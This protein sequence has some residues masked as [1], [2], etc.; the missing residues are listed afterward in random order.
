[1]PVEPDHS[2]A[3][4][5]LKAYA[6][7]R[8]EQAG[9]GL[10]LHP[11]MRKLLQ[12][13]VA[14][15][16]PRSGSSESSLIASLIRFWPRIS[17]AAIAVVLACVLL[18]NHRSNRT[19]RVE[20]ARV[21]YNDG[22][23]PTTPSPAPMKVRL[24]REED[25]G[26]LE[27]NLQLAE[28]SSKAAA[29]LEMLKDGAEKRVDRGS[30]AAVEK[31]A[32]AKDDALALTPMP[33]GSSS[34]RV[35]AQ[36]PAKAL[37]ATPSGSQLAIAGNR[38][39][40]GA[41]SF[42]S[43]QSTETLARTYALKLGVA[44]VTPMTNAVV[45]SQSNVFGKQAVAAYDA[46]PSANYFAGGVPPAPPPTVAP[47]SGPAG[48]GAVA[49]STFSVDAVGIRSKAEASAA[50]GM[51]AYQQGNRLVSRARFMNSLPQRR[52]AP[53]PTSSDKAAAEP[54]SK[55][56]EVEQEGQRIAIVDFD[57]SVYNGNVLGDEVR[58]DANARESKQIAQQ[59]VVNNSASGQQVAFTA[60][61]TNRTLRKLVR[62][63][64][65]L[66]SDATNQSNAN[67][68]NLTQSAL[69]S[70]Q[71]AQ[72]LTA[73]SAPA[74]ARQQTQ[75]AQ[76]VQQPEVLMLDKLDASVRLEGAKETRVQANRVS[77]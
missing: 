21:V 58:A 76:V 14:R 40:V 42:D 70:Q 28:N 65:T 64:G 34:S 52:V 59:T 60:S 3:E 73:P 30:L 77:P 56:F 33:T 18:W 54:L 31:K 48:A 50:N 20:M 62:I 44:S 51:D 36:E 67:V 12:A 47:V 35:P 9:D 69:K 61:G 46:Q 15:L 41:F 68:Q 55:S 66:K 1:M 72:Q 71:V 7:K 43:Q 74:L 39:S 49:S 25:A 6:R 2:K 13:E 4:E 23:Q 53:A 11:A 38:P 26:K 17:F 27:K 63:S 32:G 75:N 24:M 22:A 57:G 19:E 37:T 10:E 16:K 5:L 29:E 45:S 8:R